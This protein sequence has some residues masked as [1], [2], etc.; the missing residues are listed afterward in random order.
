M[1]LNSTKPDLLLQD[2]RIQ[3]YSKSQVLCSYGR[4]IKALNHQ[5][6]NMLARDLDFTGIMRLRL[7]AI[8]IYAISK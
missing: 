2:M 4:V 7:Q 5:K 3:L 6:L 8:F 1:D